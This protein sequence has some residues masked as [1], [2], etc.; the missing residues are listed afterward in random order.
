LFIPDRVLDLLGIEAVVLRELSNRLPGVVSL[1]D[2][3]G[4]SFCPSNDW[5]AKPTPRVDHD[6]LWLLALEISPNSR[7]EPRGYFAAPLDAFEARF[8]DLAVNRPDERIEGEAQ[9]V[10]TTTRR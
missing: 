10:P 9:N 1:G 6:A 3:A 5:L 8:E 7:V 2:D 4:L